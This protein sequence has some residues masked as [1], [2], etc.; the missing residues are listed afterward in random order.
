VIVVNNTAAANVGVGD[1]FHLIVEGFIDSDFTEPAGA[2]VPEPARVFLATGGL[3]L[4]SLRS[5][6]RT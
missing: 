4:L 5:W 3:V 2:A 6:R 1:P